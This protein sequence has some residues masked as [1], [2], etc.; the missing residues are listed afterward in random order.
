MAFNRLQTAYPIVTVVTTSPS[1]AMPIQNS[2][3]NYVTGSILAGFVL[4]K[5]TDIRLQATYAHSD[6][7]NPQIALGGQPYGAGFDEK[8]VTAGVKCKMSSRWIIDGKV[9]Y[10]YRTD[11]TTGGFTNYRGPLAYLGLTY[12]L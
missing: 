11:A 8:S 4:N 10:L 5:E 12:S 3:N 7:Y 2:N 1:V 6:N 9:G